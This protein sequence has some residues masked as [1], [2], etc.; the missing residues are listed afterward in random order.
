[1]SFSV[2]VGAFVATGLGFVLPD[3]TVFVDAG[4]LSLASP[5]PQAVIRSAA[6]VRAAQRV[7]S[8]SE[9][10]VSGFPRTR[11]FRPPTNANSVV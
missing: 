11:E 6:A 5:P 8:N 7:L 3:W 4:G 9:A 2:S 1:M 10:T